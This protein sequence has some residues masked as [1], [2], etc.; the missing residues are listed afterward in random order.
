MHSTAL[1]I[2]RLLQAGINLARPLPN[3]GFVSAVRHAASGLAALGD[4]QLRDESESLRLRVAREGPD[5][6]SA[7]IPAFACMV[8]AL[9]RSSQVE[10]YDVQLCAAIVLARGGVAEMQ[11]GEGKTFACAPAA[12]VHALT[13]RGVHIATPNAYLAQR[14]CEW[15]SPAFRVLG[16][17]VGLLADQSSAEAK[18]AAYL[19]DVTYGTGYEFGFDYLRDQLARRQLVGRALGQ[20]LWSKIH[21]SDQPDGRNSL[22]RQPYYAIID[23]ID[24]VLLDEAGSPLVISAPT[25][26]EAAD[27]ERT[28]WRTV[29]SH[30]CHTTGT[31]GSTRPR[32]ACS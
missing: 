10:L 28:D 16:V 6:P 31:S 17:Q 9:R 14:D 20:T 11:T 18:H 29:R 21:G 26:D 8:E 19:C 2:A 15:L 27:A 1:V 30:S 3:R 25:L 4:A 7:Q 13:G 23:E 32:E 22:Q 24:N 12:Y 5:L